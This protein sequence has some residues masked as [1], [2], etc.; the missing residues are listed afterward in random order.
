[1]HIRASEELQGRLFS[2]TG[3]LGLL[4][5]A[6]PA[7][8]LGTFAGGKYIK[9]KGDLTKEEHELAMNGNHNV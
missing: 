4:C 8:V 1:M 9:R 3:P 6:I 2:P 5:T 7:G